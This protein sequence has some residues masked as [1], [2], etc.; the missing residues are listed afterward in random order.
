MQPGTSYPITIEAFATS[1]L[2]RQ[3]HGIRIDISSSNFPH[4]VM[5]PNTGGPEGKARSHR[6]ATN[7]VFVDRD[8]ASYVLLPV[9]V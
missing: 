3:G 1:T 4:F 6:I 9:I 2:F 8:R 7:R 5:N